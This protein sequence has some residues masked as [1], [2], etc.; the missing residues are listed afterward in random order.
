[1][2]LL[3]TVGPAGRSLS[4]AVAAVVLVVRNPPRTRRSRCPGNYT[5]TLVLLPAAVLIALPSTGK[6]CHHHS[7]A[8]TKHYVRKYK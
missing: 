4:P 6:D 2:L 1:M 7:S 5:H 3:D 8:H